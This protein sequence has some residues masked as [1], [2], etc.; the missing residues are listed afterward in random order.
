MKKELF[1]GRDENWTPVALDL[2]TKIQGMLTPI[3]DEYMKMG[4][5]IRDIEYLITHAV[6]DLSL[7]YLLHWQH[8][9]LT[10]N[11]DESTS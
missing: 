4:Y 1:T 8:Q 10:E 6:T 3:F 7:M 9:Q 5:K 11:K 2:D